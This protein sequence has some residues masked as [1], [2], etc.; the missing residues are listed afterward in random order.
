MFYRLREPWAFRGWKR[1]PFAIVAESG[2]HKDDVPRFIRKE[3]FMDLLSCNGEEEVDLSQLSENSRRA[4]EE[5][6]AHGVLEQSQTRME[7]LKSYQ[8]YHVYPSRLLQNVHWSITGLCNMKCRHCLVNAPLAVHHQPSLADCLH[9]IDE[10]D[11]CGVRQVDITGG[12]P[13]IRRDFEEIVKAL[14]DRN[15]EIGL[16]Y[17]N[18]SLL[19]D[20]TLE[21]L[22]RCGQKPMFQVSFDGLG[23]H[24]WMRGVPGAEKQAARGL[25]LL[26]NHAFAANVAMNIHKGNKDC[27][28]DTANFLAELGVRT[29][30]LNAPQEL[31]R[32]KEN[33]AG[34]ALTEDEVW[35]VYRRYI[36]DFFADGMPIGIQLDGYFVCGKGSTDYSIAYVKHTDGETDWSKTLYCGI[37][38]ANVYISPEGRAMPCMGFSD[39]V[40]S[41]RFPSVLENHL[42]DLTLEGYYHDL[43]ETRLSDLLAGSPECRTCSHFSQCRGGCM[44]EGMDDEGNF[45]RPDPRVCYFFKHIGEQAV[46]DAADAAIRK[47]VQTGLQS[48]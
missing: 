44:L 37:A 3:V 17:T 13:L 14:S 21:M 38:A 15:M 29:L 39:T 7:P 16:I 45:L 5:M 2:A 34:N 33:A 19:T 20:A 25:K 48:P 32:W 26:Q 46:R 41:D 6:T 28:R 9:I 24:D 30:R 10:M 36:D 40:L 1:T 8:H 42:G 43:T 4:I 11:R 35:E 31:G 23:H 12:E 27:L 18:A 47:Y 22:A